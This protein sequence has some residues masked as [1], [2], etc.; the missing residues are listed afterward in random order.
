[1]KNR[2]KNLSSFAEWA[3]GQWE[4]LV[5]WLM[6][7]EPMLPPEKPE[8]VSRSRRFMDEWWVEIVAILMLLFLVV[9]WVAVAW[10]SIHFIMK[11][12]YE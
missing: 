12:W 4:R 11:H 1:M 8:P 9:L 6:T 10:I 3:S 2:M 5:K 7:I